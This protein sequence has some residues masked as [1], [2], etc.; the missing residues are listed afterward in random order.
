MR[1]AWLR[2]EAAVPATKGSGR[3]EAWRKGSGEL[4]RC[5]VREGP[6]PPRGHVTLAPRLHRA[7]VAAAKRLREGDSP[8]GA[9]ALGVEGVAV[10]DFVAVQMR[11]EEGMGDPVS[12]CYWKLEMTG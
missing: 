11:G 3:E 12:G 10:R 9:A 6:P 1:G 5:H 7:E 2:G 8:V 4:G